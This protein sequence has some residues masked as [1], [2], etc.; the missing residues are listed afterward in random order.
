MTGLL[1]LLARRD[2]RGGTGTTSRSQ[3]RPKA[4]V[5]RPMVEE[6]RSPDSVAPLA[7]CP[8][9]PFAKR[10][11]GERFS[12]IIWVNSLNRWYYLFKEFRRALNAF[13]VLSPDA[14]Y[15]RDNADL[16]WRFTVYLA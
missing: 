3:R 7:R 1:W 15:R 2:W 13:A 12:S 14:I 10:L 11:A 8:A 9:S 16:H 5:I 4:E 6:N